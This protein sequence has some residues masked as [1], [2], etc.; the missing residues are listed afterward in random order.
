MTAQAQSVASEAPALA[1][2]GR[3]DAGKAHGSA[4]GAGDAELATTAAQLMGMRA[5]P[6]R[7]EVERALAAKLPRGRVFAS[8]KAFVPFIK[9][10]LLTELQTAALN[11]GITPLKVASSDVSAAAKPAPVETPP[12][13][14]GKLAVKQPCGWGDIQVGAIVLAAAAPTYTQWFE[15]LVLAVEGEDG[16]SLR[17]C[18]YPA[19]RPFTCRRSEVGLLHPAYTPEPPLEPEPAAPVA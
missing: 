2:F 17:Y 10:E 7:T 11:S 12:K 6:I 16:F 9:T 13:A 18:D 4:F 15:C 1:V 14:N 5:L 3:D 8:G 19:V